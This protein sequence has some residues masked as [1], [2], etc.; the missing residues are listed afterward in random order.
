MVICRDRVTAQFYGKGNQDGVKHTFRF[1]LMIA[2]VV[3]AIAIIVFS[4][5]GSNLIGLYLKGE[6]GT[7]DITSNLKPCA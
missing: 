2:T 7:G 1:K 6:A 5:F 4:L 3:T